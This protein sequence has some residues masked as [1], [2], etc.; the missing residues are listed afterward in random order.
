MP[1]GTFETLA[2]LGVGLD[3]IIDELGHGNRLEFRD[4][5][6]FEVKVR[7]ARV[8]RNPATGAEIKIG[9]SKTVGFKPSPSFKKSL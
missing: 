5:G 1:A 6:V 3:E 8:G 7:K 4:F 9:P 2:R